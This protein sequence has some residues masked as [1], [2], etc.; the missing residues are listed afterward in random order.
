MS[1]L[2]EIARQESDAIAKKNALL[3]PVD[4]ST[5]SDCEI[6]PTRYAISQILPRKHVTLFGSHGG[7]GKTILAETLAAHCAT[8]TPWAGLPTERTPVLF[9]GLED[10]GELARFRLRRT[11]DE[12]G[13]LQSLVI[14]N[15][16]MLDGSNT[17]SVLAEEIATDGVRHLAFTEALSEIETTASAMGCGL[18]VIDNAS[19]AYAAN[20]NDRRMVKTFVRRLA[21]LARKVDCAVLLL[22]HVDKAAARFGGNGNTFSGS[23]AWHNSVRSRL[24]LIE[25]ES[26][27]SLVQEKNNLGKKI[28]PIRLEWTS[29]GV[30]V[31]VATTGSAAVEREVQDDTDV[32]AAIRAATADGC[33]VP[34]ARTGPS[35]ALGALAKY[36]DLPRPLRKDSPR[37]W[38]AL[39]R[40][41]RSGAVVRERYKNAHRH[42]RERL[43]C[44][45]SCAPNIPHTPCALTRAQDASIASVVRQ[46]DRRRTDASAHCPRCNDAGC[47]WCRREDPETRA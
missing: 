23:T 31:P 44:A 5:L 19:D 11:C 15:M 3:V 41:E 30:L 18:L 47:A 20:E 8:G 46:S 21:Q 27:L 6:D 36:P 7:S 33:N 35:T 4:L 25:D 43:V 39:T 24:A 14:E 29:T 26:G 40:I 9:I 13:L 1:R 22:A 10:P 38:A 37:F 32:L 2:A 34:A 45:N 28:E 12:Y 16:A 42:D 17:N